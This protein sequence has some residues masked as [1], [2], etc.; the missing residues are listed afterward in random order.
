MTR[1]YGEFK[2]DDERTVQS[3]GQTKKMI[4]SK[5]FDNTD[6]GYRKITVER[7]LRLR[8]EITADGLNAL[9]KATPFQNLAKSKK[10]AKKAK[11]AEEQ[12]GRQ[13]QAAITR[14]LESLDAGRVWMDRAEFLADLTGVA[15]DADVK[16]PAPIKKAIVSAF[17]ERDENAAICLDK[18]GHPEPDPELR[19][20]EYVPLKEDIYAYFERE[21]KPYVADAWIDESKQDEQ[22]GQVGIVGYEIPLN[23]HFYVYQPPRDLADIEADIAK[24]EKEIVAE[25]QEV[26]A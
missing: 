8:F 18:D 21:V 16:L 4:A 25:L 13:H 11:A 5:L 20:Y 12:A 7:P 2:H 17:G 15:K 6:F 24:L 26:V 22:D 3:N 19:D 10:K 1:V 9:R 14:V 23:R